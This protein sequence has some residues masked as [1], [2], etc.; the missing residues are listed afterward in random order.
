MSEGVRR[1]TASGSAAAAEA[2]IHPAARLG[3]QVSVGPWSLIDADVEVGDGTWIDAHVVIRGPTRI[4]RNNR[5]YAFCSLG[6]DPQDKKYDPAVGPSRLIIGDGNTIREYCTINRGTAHGGGVTEVGNHNWI[7]AYCHIAH[8]CR[9][10]HHT[11]FANHATL[12]GHVEVHDHVTL[13]GFTGVHQFCRLGE[14]SFTAIASV[15]VKDVPPFVMVAGNTASPR[16]INKIGLQRRGLAEADIQAIRRAFKTL[17]REGL[18]L[19]EAMTGLG[20]QAEN[21]VYVKT[22]LEFV[23]NSGRGICR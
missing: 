17:Y 12:A 9:V 15:V 6:Q 11:V 13:G 22:M 23:G 7:M 8:D 14:S 21:S 2:C 18:P 4:G 19:A 20:Q 16:A 10:G 5:I 3:S 1:A